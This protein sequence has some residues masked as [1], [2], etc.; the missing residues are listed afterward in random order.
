MTDVQ[1]MQ[2]RLTKQDDRIE[3]MLTLMKQMAQKLKS[4]DCNKK[5]GVAGES[6][7]AKE[8]KVAIS[9]KDPH[10]ILQEVSEKGGPWQF[11]FSATER[12]AIETLIPKS[13]IAPELPVDMW[14]YVKRNTTQKAKAAA[15][16]Q[17]MLALGN[18]FN[19]LK[20]IPQLLK[21]KDEKGINKALNATLLMTVMEMTKFSTDMRNAGREAIEAPKI[22]AKDKAILTS[23]EDEMYLT[24]KRKRDVLVQALRPTATNGA[25]RGKK[26]YRGNKPTSQSVTYD[27]KDEVTTDAT[28]DNSGGRA[29]GRGN[30]GGRG[31]GGGRGTSRG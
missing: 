12:R 15:A 22:Q 19:A 1:K 24:R 23:S 4:E 7:P 25:G 16:H 14:A 10:D 21:A 11:E 27:G 5:I 31:R 29:S 6:D 20:E 8:F 18:V 13:E 26:R 17:S 28:S 9:Q 30:R 3:S 2:E